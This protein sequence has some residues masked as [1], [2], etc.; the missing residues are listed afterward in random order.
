MAS[1][2]EIEKRQMEMVKMYRNNP[3]AAARDLLGIDLFVDSSQR[4]EHRIKNIKDQFYNEI[5]T[6]G[7]EIYGK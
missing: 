6:K 3:A 2:L 5:F 7:I 4:I 1:S